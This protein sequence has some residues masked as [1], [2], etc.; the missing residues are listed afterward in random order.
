MPLDP[1]VQMLLDQLAQAGGPTLR[2]AGVEQGRAMLQTLASMDAEPPAIARVEPLTLAGS[3]SAR[4]YAASTDTPLPILVWYHGGGFV[5]GDL[6]TAD[7]TCRTLAAKTGALVISVDYSL[8]PEHPFPAGPDDCIAA[9]RWVI[10]NAESL[11]GDP[12]RVAI[13]GDSA[14]G[15]LTAVTA[16][17]ARDEGIPLRFQLLVYPVTDCTMTSSSYTANAEGYLLTADAM[18]WFI[19]LYLSGHADA[20]D[21]RVSPLYA[22]DLRGLAP[23]LVITAEFDPLRDE[24][25]AYAERLK[26]AGNN[27][28]TRRFDGQIHGFFA[29][30]AVIPTANEAV[31][32]A[33]DHLS[34]A[35]S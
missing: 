20:K 8:A 3:I 21:P 10:D 31:A 18:D 33:A 34:N 22:D 15:N 9:L 23:A 14:G 25:E 7:R 29:M 26:E 16:I 35:L 5:I 13:G 30:G 27:V 32:L 1:A 6:D 17:Q 24:G 4:L 2:E 12:S 19:D 11:G 28:T